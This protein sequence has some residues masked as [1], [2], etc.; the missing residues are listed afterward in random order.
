MLRH[1][2]VS[3]RTAVQ[4][5]AIGLLGMG[6]S[7][8][9]ALQAA[10]AAATGAPT[11]ATARSCIYIFL[12]GGLSQHE[13]FDPKPTAPREVRGEFSAI[14]T[15]N[16]GLDICEHL[17]GLAQ[18]SNLWSVVRSLTHPSNEHTLGH[19]FMLTGRSVTNPGFRGDRQPR[20]TDWPSLASIVG[21]ALPSRSNLPPAVVLPE[22]L[23]HWSGGTIPGAYGGQMGSHRDPFFV[24]ASPYGDPFW[25]GAYPE[26]TFPNLTLKPPLAP[27]NR[28]Y[29]APSLALATD[30]TLS[31]MNSRTDLLQTLDR[32][33]R[34]LEGSVATTRYDEYRQSAISLL[35][36]PS[37]RQAFDVTN[38][39][40]KTQ[41]RYGR[42]SFGWSLLMARQLVESGVNLV[43]VN[44]GNNETWDTHG[45]IFH[46][47]RNKLLPPT[48]RAL[49]A[50][51]DD[52]QNSGLLESTLIVMGSEF[53][54]TPQLSTLA[55]SF[56]APG[57]DHWGAVQSVFFAGGGIRGGTVIGSSDELG[58]Y[59]ASAPQKP[60][61]MAA[62][63]YSALGIPATAVWQDEFHRPH[64]IYH[65]EPIPGLL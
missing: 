44:L 6:T 7:D 34:M 56:P 18:R 53:G 39:D 11:T 25:R 58:A 31:R 47:M 46:R 26:Y 23:V 57:R 55:D 20:A 37:I 36:S 10:N 45:D 15:Q 27:D 42:N 28:V 32:Q 22:R 61:N 21:D 38:A 12:S 52:L 60:E 3:R 50:L 35:S 40:Q 16:P 48:D 14:S 9:Q 19:Y 49:C 17:P 13:S 8:L 51:L 33:R 54:R 59:P 1:P 5:G 41:E 64:Q 62:T 4:A 63:I 24:E 29:Q 2:R 43:Q 30:M 65:G